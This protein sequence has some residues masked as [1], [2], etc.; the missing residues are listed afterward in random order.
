MADKMDKKAS[1][2]L[3]ALTIAARL[4]QNPH[5]ISERQWTKD[6]EVSPSFFS[7]LR[8]TPTKPPS[9]PSVDQLRKM[10]S[11]RGLNLAEFF[12]EEARG[13][14][15]RVPTKQALEQALADVW[16]G[17]PKGRDRQIA[18]VAENVLRALQLPE[19][20]AAKPGEGLS[21]DLAAHAG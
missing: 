3:S 13:K 7:N 1:A 21:D 20:E 5:P 18:Y 16:E 17:L 6:A 19:N 8:G 11:V 10:L 2:Q 9:D 15:V 14:L 4:A 12:L